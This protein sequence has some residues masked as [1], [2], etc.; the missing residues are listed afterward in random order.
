MTQNQVQSAA[1]LSVWKEAGGLL[2][3]V[4]ENPWRTLV[5]GRDVPN[6]LR[7]WLEEL[8][9]IANHMVVGRVQVF[10]LLCCF[11]VVFF[12]VLQCLL[13]SPGPPASPHTLKI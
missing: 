4:D 9:L 5:R 11:Y 8:C 12:N 3:H 10:K 1:W 6:Q 13:G 7:C 2:V